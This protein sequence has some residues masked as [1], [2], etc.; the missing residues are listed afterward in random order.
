MSN[1][2]FNWPGNAGRI[3]DGITARGAH[4]NNP[5]DELTTGLNKLPSQAENNRGSRNYG[6]AGGAANAYTLTL[7]HVSAYAGGQDVYLE[8]PATLANTGASTLNVSGIGAVAIVYPDNT[9]LASGELPVGSI[10]HLKYSATLTKWILISSAIASH[11]GAVAALAAQVAAETAQGLAEVAQ[12]AAETAE[13]GAETAETNINNSRQFY[14]HEAATPDLTVVLNAGTVQNGTTVTTVAEQTTAAFTAPSGNPRIDR[15]VIDEVTGVYSV[16]AGSEAASPTAPAIPIGKI[17]IAQVLLDNS[18]ATTEITNSLITDERTYAYT[19][20]TAGLIQEVVESDATYISPF[21]ST[22]ALDDTIPLITEGTEIE[23]VAITPK[24]ADSTLE[25][26]VEFT[27]GAT[28]GDTVIY[29]LIDVTAGATLHTWVCKLPPS[30][31][32]ICLSGM[33]RVASPG[34]SANTYSLRVGTASGSIEINGNSGSRVLGGALSTKM[35][36]REVR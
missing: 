23:T 6:V 30:L 19:S 7:A 33:C 1:D 20:T 25:F 15:I 11:S 22:I 9:A 28:A 10:A 27:A 17:A 8:I 14:A 5:L 29:S 13:T 34:T 31:D 26:D 35:R 2:Y 4:V 32:L 24:F 3:S 18:P 36:A 12:A 16:V 21:T